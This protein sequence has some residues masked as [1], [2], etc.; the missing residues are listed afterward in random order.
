MGDTLTKIANLVDPEVMADMIHATLPTKIKFSPFA[1]V[2]ATLV[3]QPGDTITVPKYAYI[4]DA[5]D[6]AEGEDMPVRQ[7]TAS[8]TKVKVKKA[9]NAI[10]ITDEAME[11]GYGDPVGE[12]TAQL[13][14]SIASKI[15]ADCY[16]ALKTAKTAYTASGI[17]GYTG[18]VDAVDLFDD[19]NDDNIDK[20]IFVHP[21]QVTQLR[22]DENFLDI[23][24]YPVTN[25]VIMSGMIG[26]IAGCRVVKSKKVVKGDDGIYINPIMVVST[27]DPKEDPTAD[28][29]GTDAPALTIYLKRDI[30]VE[31]DRDILKGVNVVA[32]NEHYAVALSNDSKVVLAK[33]KAT[34]A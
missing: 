34:A 24:K 22:K 14:M 29:T 6:V 8:T 33:F 30:M 25:G 19:E 32:A 23:N 26:T 31:N 11:S 1:R 17:I 21:S 4:G 7:L 2:D 9:G 28:A 16:A 5:V 15:D 3:G 13:S 20:V 10:E 18:I 12:G 27:A